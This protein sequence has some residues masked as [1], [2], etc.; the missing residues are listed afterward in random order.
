MKLKIISML[1][2]CMSCT[3]AQNGGKLKFGTDGIVQSFRYLSFMGKNRE[4][5]WV[6][7]KGVIGLSECDSTQAIKLLMYL[8]LKLNREKD[9][10]QRILQENGGFKYQQLKT[11]L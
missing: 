11:T 8:Y 4:Q 9:S 10:L 6:D 5:V 3:M 7:E 2:L 1:F